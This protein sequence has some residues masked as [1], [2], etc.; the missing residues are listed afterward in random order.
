M[1]RIKSE[2][3]IYILENDSYSHHNEIILEGKKPK[4]NLRAEEQTHLSEPGG[5]GWYHFSVI[6]KKQ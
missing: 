5:I 6:I 1:Q 4:K 3:F 2:I